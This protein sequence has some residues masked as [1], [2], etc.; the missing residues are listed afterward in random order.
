MECIKIIYKYFKGFKNV[1]VL[2]LSKSIPYIF[3]VY[4][5]PRHIFQML[6]EFFLKT[7]IT[8]KRIINKFIKEGKNYI[9]AFLKSTFIDFIY[10][11][12][13]C[14]STFIEYTLKYFRRN[15]FKS[16]FLY[17]TEIDI[18]L[19]IIYEFFRLSYN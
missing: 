12:I 17:L 1:I 18:V 2:L 9:L 19:N 7:V 6:F 8:Y 3:I 14:N 15:V 5:N 11:S 13:L 10:K 16:S 4:L